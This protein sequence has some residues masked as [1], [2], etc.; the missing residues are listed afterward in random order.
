MSL[1]SMLSR[2]LASRT[3]A[4]SLLRCAPRQTK[5]PRRQLARSL[6]T[7]ALEVADKPSNYGQPLYQSHPHLVKPGELTPGIPHEEYELRRKALM[8][9][10]PDNSVVVCAAAPIKYMSGAI[11]YKYRQASDFWYLTGFEEPDSAVILEKTSTSK[12]Y[13]MTLFCS[14]KNMA[15]EKWDGAKTGLGEA[16]AIFRA[17]DTRSIDHFADHLRSLTSLYSHVFVDLDGSNTSR[18]RSRSVL[19]FLSP[20]NP[21]KSALETAMETFSLPASKRRPLSAEVAKLRAIKSDAEMRVMRAAGD[22][23]GRAHAKTMR[24]AQP[25][26]NEAQLAAHFAYLCSLSG[27]QRQA[28]VPVVA[29]GPNALIIHYTSNNQLVRA[30]EL[31]LIDAGC[32]YNGYA[33]DIT[34]TFPASGV[35]PPAQRDIY[36]AVLSAQRELV[37]MCTASSGH[38]LYTIHRESRGMLRAELNQLPGFRL[39]LADVDTL[40]PHFVSH[41][42]GIDLHESSNFDRSG[43][44]RK[45]MV[46]T[47]EPGI[48]VP[49]TAQFPKHFHDIGVRIEDEVAVGE[50]HPTVLSVSAPKEIADVEA[51][52][53]G[54]LG[55]EPY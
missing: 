20:S 23:S 51:A 25:G 9:S 27:S 52:C 48:Y 24:F 11:F 17:D 7:E 46:I 47:I 18:R 39:D 4:P 15:Q 19:K 16:T 8:N 54:L 5:C 31:V 32:E 44:L 43:E 37:K 49:P 35:F 36:Q 38:S 40:Y 28:Y 26:M 6:A 42:I 2:R 30:G 45:G 50:R 34:R 55:L 21:N 29:S 14:G 3:A 41:P 12:G 33:S 22:I 53:Q 1:S 10:L 13:R